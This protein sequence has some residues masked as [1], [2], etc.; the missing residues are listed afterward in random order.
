MAYVLP[1]GFLPPLCRSCGK[2]V[3]KYTRTIRPDHG[4]PD[5]PRPKPDEIVTARRYFPSGAIRYY[6]VWDGRTYEDEFFCT[7]RCAAL[8]GRL[9]ASGACVTS[10]AYSDALKRQRGER[11]K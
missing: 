4:N 5:G 1:K 7:T 2:P 6:V 9:S 10:V 11:V 8:F 3:R